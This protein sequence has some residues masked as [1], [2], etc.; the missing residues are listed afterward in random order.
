MEKLTNCKKCGK[1]L[2]RRQRYYCSNECKLT[3]PEAIKIRN[4]GKEK[5]DESKKIKCLHTG[6]TFK[7]IK[8]YSG[9]LTRHIEALKLKGVEIK[10]NLFDNFEIIDNPNYNNPKYH[11][12]YCDWTTKDIKN[13]SGCITVHLKDI[14]NI[15]PTEHIKKYPEEENMWTYKH[16][17]DLREYFLSDD[18]DK[19]IEC[20]ICGKKLKKISYTH[21]ELH[22]MTVD[23]YKSKF[24]LEVLSCIETRE[25]SKEIYKKA[26]ENYCRKDYTSVP[27]REI[28][29]FLQSIGVDIR[30][31]NRNVIE[32]TEIDM[33]SSEHKIAI[34]FD[35]L[36][37]HSEF[38]GKKM[39]DYHLSKTKKCAEKGVRLIHIF[40][41]EWK[42]K[43]EIVKNRLTHIFGKNPEK[44]Y[45]RKCEIKEI[46]VREKSDFLEKYHI[47]GPDKSKINVGL[48]HN[49]ELVSV[50]T[51][52]N[53]R[54]ALGHTDRNSDHYELSRLC[55]KINVI[56]GASKMIKYFIKKYSPKKIISYADKRWSSSVDHTVYTKLG[57]NY[58]G[59][60]APNYWYLKNYRDR[61]H[62]F[63]FTK[64]RILKEMGGDP[65]LT[66]IENMIKMRYDR[67]W[68]CGS[69]KY[70]MIL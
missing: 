47:Q 63:N 32:L 61:Y 37:Y 64:A 46:S 20:L 53:L 24:N 59:D 55:S 54:A 35:G 38:G 50:M 40:E 17:E 6:K 49:D 26:F 5:Q 4:L 28:Q 31:K 45:A 66:E 22:G 48:F 57:F 29:E 56:G 51:F 8:N 65:N 44:V 34:E 12:K 69:L 42:Q 30:M 41:D 25:K 68:D 19:F 36:Y 10:E 39:K 52:S 18:E 13:K 21:L 70:E 1:E 62:R 27:E 7:D 60:T 2:R 23:E 9:V 16:S 15:T 11:C 33:Y 67:I 58:I 3:D 14:H 43:R